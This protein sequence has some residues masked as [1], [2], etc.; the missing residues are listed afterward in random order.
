MC[1]KG[2][3]LRNIILLKDE[4]IF[5]NN[6]FSVSLKYGLFTQQDIVIRDLKQLSFDGFSRFK[7]YFEVDRILIQIIFIYMPIGYLK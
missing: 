6:L 5:N 3:P 2:D 1:L 7:A 4:I